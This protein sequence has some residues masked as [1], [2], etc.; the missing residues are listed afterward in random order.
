MLFI[1]EETVQHMYTILL[2]VSASTATVRQSV[3]EKIQRKG[4]SN[5]ERS[6]PY[7]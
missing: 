7:K 2:H 5:E 1:Y 6:L 3:Y 4:N